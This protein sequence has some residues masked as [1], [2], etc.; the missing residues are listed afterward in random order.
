MQISSE[1]HIPPRHPEEIMA[2][3]VVACKLCNGWMDWVSAFTLIPR[4]RHGYITSD[5]YI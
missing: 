5:E 1:K 3:V 2:A 4:A